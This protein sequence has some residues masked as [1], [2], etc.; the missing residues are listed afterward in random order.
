M[1][2]DLLLL[3]S[4]PYTTYDRN[5]QD[6]DKNQDLTSVNDIPLYARDQSAPS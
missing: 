2:V 6:N 1:M 5:R 3:K 4:I